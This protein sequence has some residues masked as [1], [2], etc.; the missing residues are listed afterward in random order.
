MLLAEV[1]LPGDAVPVA[2]DAKARAP[3]LLLELH[4]HRATLGKLCHLLLG[5]CG[6]VLGAHDGKAESLVV[7]GRLVGIC[8]HEVPAV[9]AQERVH[10]AIVPLGWEA[11][12]LAGDEIELA[13]ENGLVEGHGFAGIAGESEVRSQSSHAP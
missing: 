3:L 11:E 8:G 5:L 10:D 12:V 9:S 6:L 13:A 4:F 7:F 1:G 2:H